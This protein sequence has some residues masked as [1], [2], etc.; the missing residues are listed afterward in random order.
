MPEAVV[1][2]SV[3][4]AV[5]LLVVGALALAYARGD[6]LILDLAAGVAAFFCL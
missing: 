5:S 4:V 6:A 2:G 1:K 3:F